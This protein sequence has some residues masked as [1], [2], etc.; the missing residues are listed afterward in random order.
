MKTIVVLL[1]TLFFSNNIHAQA[2]NIVK[3]FGKSMNEWTVT[4]E[5]THRDHI[6]S[7]CAKSSFWVSDNIAESIIS[8][9]KESN[10]SKSLTLDSY[11]NWFEES[12]RDS[13]AVEFSDY[14]LVDKKDII[15]ITKFAKEKIRDDDREYVICKISISGNIFFSE[16]ILVCVRDNKILA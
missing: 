13:M 10:R 6:E 9:M 15:G 5:L 4:H 1:F 11:L 14:S 16:W 3:D 7:L 8:R 2:V 12:I